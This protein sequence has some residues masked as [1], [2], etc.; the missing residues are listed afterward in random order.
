MEDIL[1]LCQQDDAITSA[2]MEVIFLNEPAQHADGLTRELFS[3]GWKRILPLFFEGTNFHVPRVDPDCSKELF[4]ILGR[5]ARHGFVLTGYFPIGMA[6]WY[7]NTPITTMSYS[8]WRAWLCDAEILLPMYLRTETRP[9]NGNV[10][11]IS[12]FDPSPADLL[13]RLRWLNPSAL[14]FLSV[15]NTYL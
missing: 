7:F 14:S 11:W 8:L 1:E 3:Q 12:T 9:V 6:Q 5:I 13:L 15:P 4:K 10:K 2:T